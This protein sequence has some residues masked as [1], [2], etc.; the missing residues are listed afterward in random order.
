MATQ[1]IRAKGLG[2]TGVNVLHETGMNPQT[3]R[4]LQITLDDVERAKNMLETVM[5]VDVQPRKDWLVANPYRPVIE[6]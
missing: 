2:E 4:Y 1:N 5:G 6:D 3:R